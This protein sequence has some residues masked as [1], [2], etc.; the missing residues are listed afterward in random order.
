MT[1]DFLT[2]S[3]WNRNIDADVGWLSEKTMSKGK[4]T[5]RG[6]YGE[7]FHVSVRKVSYQNGTMIASKWSPAKLTSA[8]V[9]IHSNTL[10]SAVLNPGTAANFS[11]ELEFPRTASYEI[12]LSKITSTSGDVNGSLSVFLDTWNTYVY[13][14]RHQFM[15]VSLFLLPI[16]YFFFANCFFVLPVL[17]V[18]FAGCLFV[19]FA[20]CFFFCF[21]LVGR[22]FC[23]LIV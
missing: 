16:G 17:D 11:V 10:A 8:K 2:I 4:L 22:L 14:T 3:A 12:Y 23:P 21:H 6:Q 15:I 1:K 18:C 5:W 7:A 13:G 20:S 9:E 19:Y